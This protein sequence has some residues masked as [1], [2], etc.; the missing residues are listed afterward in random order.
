MIFPTII[1]QERKSD[2]PILPSHPSRHTSTY[3][4]STLS[5]LDETNSCFTEG[6]IPKLTGIF[7]PQKC[8]EGLVRQTRDGVKGCFPKEGEG[9]CSQLEIP[10]ESAANVPPRGTS[11]KTCLTEGIFPPESERD[12]HYYE[13]KFYDDLQ[14]CQFPRLTKRKDDEERSGCFSGVGILYPSNNNPHAPSTCFTEGVLYEPDR[15]VKPF[16]HCCPGLVRQTREE[17]VGCFNVTAA[18]QAV[19]KVA[20]EAAAKAAEEAAACS[21]LDPPC[22]STFSTNRQRKSCMTEGIFPDKTGFE[23]LYDDLY[24]SNSFDCCDGLTKRKDDKK[25]KGCF[26]DKK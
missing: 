24:A 23:Q 26:P 17:G 3:N 15:K 16:K 18:Q 10:C 6:E 11:G 12:Q 14:C 20:E 7:H 9:A 5:T 25:R 4:M 13:G 22:E 2:T 1:L 8:C 19:V 21:M